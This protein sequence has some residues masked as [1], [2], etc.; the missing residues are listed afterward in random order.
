ML[1]SISDSSVDCPSG[2][3]NKKG[4][5]KSKEGARAELHRCFL[6]TMGCPLGV[7][8][9]DLEIRRALCGSDRRADCR[10]NRKEVARRSMSLHDMSVEAEKGYFGCDNGLT[11]ISWFSPNGPSCPCQGNYGIEKRKKHGV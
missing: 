5:R 1:L 11:D 7:D 10:Q 8:A 6:V 3:R 9:N 2:E 4:S